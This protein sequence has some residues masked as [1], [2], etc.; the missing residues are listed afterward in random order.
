MQNT[1]FLE[2]QD[3]EYVGIALHL[4]TKIGKLECDWSGLAS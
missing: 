3:Y 2:I 1:H 4:V